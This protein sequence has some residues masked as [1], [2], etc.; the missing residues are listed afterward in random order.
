MLK[1]CAAKA[2]LISI[3]I[4]SV[5]TLHAQDGEKSVKM[6]DLPEV[7]QKTVREQSK[8]A[9]VRGLAKEIENGKTY[10]EAELRVR[11]LTKDIL[12][13]ETGAVVEIEEQVL[14]T[15]LPEAVRAQIKSSAGKGKIRSVEAITKNGA[16]TIYEALVT[17]GGKKS[18]IQVA[19]DGK[20]ISKEAVKDVTGKK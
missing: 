13:D 2:C 4:L 11:G 5:G 8:G 16:P 19:A 10:Y 9:V 6:K 15:T 17:S 12:I 14:L 1:I 3:C 7:V 18:E 20:L